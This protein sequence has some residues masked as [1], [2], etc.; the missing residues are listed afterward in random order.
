M[1]GVSEGERVRSNKG[2][3]GSATGLASETK[4]GTVAAANPGGGSAE[5]G[6]A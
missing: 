4:A 1:Q 2:K 3:V 5:A 6:G